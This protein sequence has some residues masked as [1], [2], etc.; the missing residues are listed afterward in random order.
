MTDEKEI[1]QEAGKPEEGVKPQEVN[2]PQ[3][4]RGRPT[5]E[6]AARKAASRPGRRKGSKNKSSEAKEEEI[7]KQILC[8][9]TMAINNLAYLSAAAVSEKVRYDSSKTIIELGLGIYEK[10]APKPGKQVDEQKPEDNK[11]TGKVFP[12]AAKQ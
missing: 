12:F 9:V 5:R 3:K 4:K 7:R 8:N 2:K 10:A 1:T 6:E 11:P